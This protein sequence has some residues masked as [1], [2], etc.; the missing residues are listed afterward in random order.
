MEIVGY[1]GGALL[2]LCAIPEAIRTLQ[3]KKC[4]ISWG[5]L[6]MWFSGE[7][8]MFA[9]T[10]KF[11]DWALMGNYLFNIVILSPMIYYKLKEEIKRCGQK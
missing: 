3:D 7:V 4:H 6:L 9:Y 8:C 11:W 5:F 10:T 1:L 2:G